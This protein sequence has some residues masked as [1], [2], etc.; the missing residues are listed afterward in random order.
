MIL[1]RGGSGPY[2]VNKSVIR[3][4]RDQMA[5]LLLT[6]AETP[7]HLLGYRMG[8]CVD[9]CSSKACSRR[10]VSSL[11]DELIE[12]MNQSSASGSTDRSLT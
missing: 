6:L 11:L 5:S 8:V 1:R 4:R 3:L 10:L 9:F 7:P 2:S 12:A